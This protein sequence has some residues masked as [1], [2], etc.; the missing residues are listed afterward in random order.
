MHLSFKYL[1]CLEQL[2]FVP[3]VYK[4]RSRT[5][6]TPLGYEAA[7]LKIKQWQIIKCKQKNN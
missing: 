7:F 5:L 6:E 2:I 1:L 4:V 3:L